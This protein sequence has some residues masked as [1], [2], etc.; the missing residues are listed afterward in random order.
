MRMEL[1]S[2][3]GLIWIIGAETQ[4]NVAVRS[5]HEGVPSHWNFWKSTIVG[6]EACFFF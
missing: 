4:D 6:V 2:S 1:E 5:H 3:G